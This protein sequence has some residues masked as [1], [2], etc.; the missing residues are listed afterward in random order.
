M[1]DNDPKTQA[2]DQELCDTRRKLEET[3]SLRQ[4]LE[5]TLSQVRTEQRLRDK[6]TAAGV[7]DMEAAI[8]LAEQRL[9][10]NKDAKPEQVI[11]QL[12]REKPYL[13]TPQVAPQAMQPTRGKKDK[14]G[15]A[16]AQQNTKPASADRRQLMQYMKTRRK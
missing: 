16:Q 9:T 14:T 3:E 7:A 8:L 5:Q 13:F 11:D 15:P 6:L 1:T 10:Q 2:A 4:Q 12:K